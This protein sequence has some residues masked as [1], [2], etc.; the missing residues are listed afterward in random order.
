MHNSRRKS[1]NFVVNTKKKNVNG[2]LRTLNSRMRLPS[3]ELRW[4]PS[5]KNCRIWWIPSLVW[6][7]RLPPT[8]NCWR[9][10]RTGKVTLDQHSGPLYLTD[11][12]LITSNHDNLYCWIK[13]HQMVTLWENR[14]VEL[15]F[16][17][18]AAAIYT[19]KYTCVASFS[20]QIW[21]ILDY[22][23]TKGY[24]KNGRYVRIQVG[25]PVSYVIFCIATVAFSV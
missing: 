1:N 11:S 5:S 8:E 10:R 2:R 24:R 21:D 22:Y 17:E 4:K 13:I 19:H 25:E 23:T 16:S 14:V 6:N 20:T 18:S 3:W 9:V 15:H 12:S 7:W